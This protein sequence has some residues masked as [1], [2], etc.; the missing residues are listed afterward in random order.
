MDPKTHRLYLSAATPDAAPPRPSPPPPARPPQGRPSPLRAR[1]VR[2]PRRRRVGGRASDRRACRV[3]W[4]VLDHRC[5]F[6]VE[7]GRVRPCL[8]SLVA[9]GVC[10]GFRSSSRGLGVAGGRA[11]T[12]EPFPATQRKRFR[13]WSTIPGHTDRLEK[14]PNR[15]LHPKRGNRVADRVGL[16]R[17]FQRVRPHRGHLRDPAEEARLPMRSLA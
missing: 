14:L 9:A 12:P 7:R 4:V 10:S 11:P 1:I 13:R 15:K 3:T 5:A 16:A 6:A 2:R 17:D 8:L